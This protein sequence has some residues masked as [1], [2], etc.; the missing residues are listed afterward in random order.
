MTPRH[1]KDLSIWIP[2]VGELEEEIIRLRKRIQLLNCM[3]ISAMISILLLC[4]VIQ[5]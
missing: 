1:Q 3:V 4:M 5:T 2:R